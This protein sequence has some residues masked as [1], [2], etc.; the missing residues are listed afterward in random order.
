MTIQTERMQHG[1]LHE[2]QYTFFCYT[3]TPTDYTNI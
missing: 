1:I 2:E 3:Y